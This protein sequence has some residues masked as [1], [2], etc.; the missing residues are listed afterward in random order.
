ME[1]I[2]TYVAS[3]RLPHRRLLYGCVLA[4]VCLGC[5]MLVTVREDTHG[6]DKTGG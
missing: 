6:Q 2:F 1:T 4:I 3:A 5:W